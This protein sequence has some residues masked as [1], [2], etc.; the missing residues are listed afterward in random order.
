MFPHLLRSERSGLRPSSMAGQ[1][2]PAT[3]AERGQAL[4]IIALAMIGLL[5]FVGLT[6]DSGILFIG[7]GH[8]RRAVDAAALAAA[9][10]F[11][12]GRA[13]DQLLDAAREVVHLNGVEPSSLQLFWCDTSDTDPSHIEADLCPAHPTDPHR[14]LIRVVAKT[15]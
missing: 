10:Q 6:V 9:S 14:K 3:L 12:E 2:R 1:R 11:R 15:I 8:L 7:V 13:Y 5:A 4:V